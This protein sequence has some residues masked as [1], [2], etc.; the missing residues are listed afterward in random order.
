MVAMTRDRITALAE[1]IAS[2]PEEAQAEIEQSVAAAEV[3]Y[4]A[5]YRLSPEERAGV[6]RGLD[7]MR[8]GEFVPDEQ[9]KAFF[10]RH[11]A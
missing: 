11:R 1:R 3:R 10:A 6:E 2:L 9:V 4:G 7:Q 5:V 8:R